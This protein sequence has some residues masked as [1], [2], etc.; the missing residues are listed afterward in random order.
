MMVYGLT[1]FRTV[2]LV[3]V[4]ALSGGAR[5]QTLPLELPALIPSEPVTVY[6]VPGVSDDR[7]CVKQ[8]FRDDSPCDPLIFKRVDN[9]CQN[10]NSRR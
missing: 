1:M 5:A 2:S 3:A 6:D 7:G 4:L 9:R 8:C 10:L